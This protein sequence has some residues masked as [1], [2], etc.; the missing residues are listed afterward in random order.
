MPDGTNAFSRRLVDHILELEPLLLPIGAAPSVPPHQL[1]DAERF[2]EQHAAIASILS[3]VVAET[4][5][6]P[7]IEFGA[8][9]GALS[10]A[11][12]EAK[13]A[14]NFVLVDRKPPKRRGGGFGFKPVRLCVDVETLPPAELRA[15]APRGG[16]VLSNH[17]C[18]CA[19]DAAV[20]C[21]VRAFDVPTAREGGGGGGGGGGACHLAAVIAVSC[22][23]HKCDWES[24]LGRRFF[25]SLGLGA[26]EFELIRKWSR[27]AA[28]RNKPSD[29]RERVVQLAADLGISTDGA[30]ELGALCRRLLDTGRLRELER[31]GYEV[32][33]LRHVD[34]SVTADNVMLLAV[35]RGRGR[36]RGVQ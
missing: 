22:C 2:A 36:A 30:V 18:G 4:G 15:C 19:L 25:G 34:F 8:G 27:A 14:S 12:W 24:Y 9:D 7:V 23:H 16:L 20:H 33:I 29:T 17:M 5:P 1:S 6:L 31:R 11:L 13:A 32:A 3:A 28:R 35:D 26:R 10:H 21:A